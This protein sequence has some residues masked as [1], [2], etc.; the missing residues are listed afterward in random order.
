MIA[1]RPLR[2]DDGATLE[3]LFGANG[4]CGGCWCMFWRSSGKD[5]RA[6]KGDANRAAFLG[7]VAG[8]AV[9][10]VLA[11]D[12]DEAVGWC[13]AGPRDDFPRIAAGRSFRKDPPPGTWSVNCFFV[14]ARRRSQ[15][16]A[17]ALLGGAI[18]L[19][20]SAGA[21]SLEAYPVTP[22]ADGRLPA[23]FAYTGVAAMFA[24][25]GFRPVS[26]GAKTWVRALRDGT[27]TGSPAGAG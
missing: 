15:G 7:K 11:F 10:G 1:T 8:G 6:G 17:T 16:V 24:T 9:R 26:P 4:A 21:S 27:F 18:A 22:K 12:G 20:T 23:A 2:P 14:P 5:F 3:R 13:G 25:A 19:A